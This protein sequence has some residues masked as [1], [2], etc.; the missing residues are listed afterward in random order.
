MLYTI[1][2]SILKLIAVRKKSINCNDIEKKVLS[3][4]LKLSSKS[5]H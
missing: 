1:F 4:H 3:L 2:L 5:T